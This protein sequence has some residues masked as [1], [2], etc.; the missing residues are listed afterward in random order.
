M[1]AAEV[2]R[3]VHLDGFSGGLSAID[4]YGKVA[5]V[6]SDRPDGS[7]DI[8]GLAGAGVLLSCVGYRNCGP[9]PV[10]FDPEVFQL[11]REGQLAELIFEARV[12]ER[13]V[14]FTDE[15]GQVAGGDLFLPPSPGR[16]RASR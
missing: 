9:G 13:L 11:D 7:E 2:E 16:R 12:V 8:P 1:V 4:E 10:T 5:H 6:I 14:L 3:M 15:Q